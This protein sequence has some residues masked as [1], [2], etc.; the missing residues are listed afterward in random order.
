MAVL[1]DAA[2]HKPVTQPSEPV[3]V[4]LSGGV[5][6]W[7]RLGP[8][9]HFFSPPS[10]LLFPR[11]GLASLIAGHLRPRQSLHTFKWPAKLGRRQRPEEILSDQQAKS[12]PPIVYS[13]YQVV[14]AEA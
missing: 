6:P 3:V 11:F 1:R 2:G 8:A 4:T 9:K 12:T 10:S 5:G 14:C 7:H 13:S